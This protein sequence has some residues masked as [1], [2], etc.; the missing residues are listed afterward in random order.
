[1]LKN[2]LERIALE[3]CRESNEENALEDSRCISLYGIIR[4]IVSNKLT[5]N[6]IHSSIAT[7]ILKHSDM[8]DFTL[9]LPKIVGIFV[10]MHLI[11]WDIIFVVNTYINKYLLVVVVRNSLFIT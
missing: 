1:M 2:T 11:K 10:K 9:Q 4:K 5:S 6:K 7:T 3:N 8:S